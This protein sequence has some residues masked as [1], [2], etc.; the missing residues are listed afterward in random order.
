[1]TFS[2][3]L[4]CASARQLA[5][6]SEILVRTKQFVIPRTERAVG[7]QTLFGQGI[8]DWNSIPVGTTMASS[9]SLFRKN[10]DD[11]F[12]RRNIFG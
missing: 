12:N 1:M 8:N 9:L 6:L 3:K 11:F 10:C 4:G 5:Y 2:Y 7:K